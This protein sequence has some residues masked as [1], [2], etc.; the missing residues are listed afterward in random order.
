MRPADVRQ[1]IAD[2][3]FRASV[4]SVFRDA[5]TEL[6]TPLPI[7]YVRLKPETGLTLGLGTGA[8]S[9]LPGG[10][11]KVFAVGDPDECVRKYEPRAKAGGWVRRVPG[12]AAVAF[13]FPLDRSLGGLPH[14]VEPQRIKHLLH[15]ELAELAPDGWRVRAKRTRIEL[16]RYKPERRAVVRARL[17][18]RHDPTGE[19]G[20]RDLVLRAHADDTWAHTRATIPQIDRWLAEADRAFRVPKVLGADPER[21]L[22]IQEWIPGRPWNPAATN[23][24][25]LDALVRAVRRLREFA[26]PSDADL[27]LPFGEAITVLE[28]LVAVAPADLAATAAALAE[29]LA[30]FES[31]PDLDPTLVHGDLHAHQFVLGNDAEPPAILDWDRAHVGDF[32]EDIACLLGHL[33]LMEMDGRLPPAAGRELRETLTREL[34]APRGLEWFV[35]A[36]LAKLAFVP[37]RNLRPDWETRTADLLR[38]ALEV[39]TATEVRR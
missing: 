6:P 27:V 10:Y 2:E 12:V 39:T 23:R 28:D 1:L 34:G 9:G 30:R 22:V 38:L 4:R 32:R 31:R 35:A 15:R 26:A 29:S 21:R 3:A 8:G 17:A 5:G 24:S 14:V 18:V 7:H 33:H 25:E 11:V 36:Q 19:D 13:G 20:V 37:F 16:L